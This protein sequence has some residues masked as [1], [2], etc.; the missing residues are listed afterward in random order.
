MKTKARALI[1]SGAAGLCALHLALTAHAA[2]D[3]QGFIRL[4][5]EEL[6]YKS[7]LGVGPESTVLFGDP[8]KPGLYVVRNKFPP[9]AHS[10]P[11]YH[12]Q[13]RHATVIKGVWWTGTG[14]ELDFKTAVPLKAGAYMLH[15]AGGVHWDGAGDEEVIV[16]IIGVGPVET[17]QVGPPGAPQ[18][19]WPK[20]K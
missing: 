14:S 7:P 5:P 15:P 8:S 19:Y 2:Q 11:H 9:G 10:A 1:F 20:P 13:D 12:S 4:D 3:A 6:H 16:Q 18:G 17:T